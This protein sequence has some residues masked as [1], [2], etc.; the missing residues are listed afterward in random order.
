MVGP[1]PTLSIAGAATGCNQ[2]IATTTTA[3]NGK[4]SAQ[5]VY[6]AISG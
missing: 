6:I 1:G 3:Q 4:I 2:V 5:N